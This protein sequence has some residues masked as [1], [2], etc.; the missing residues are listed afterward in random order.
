MRM[1]QVTWHWRIVEEILVRW[2]PY[3]LQHRYDMNQ[4]L[5]HDER[6]LPYLLLP[7]S[8]MRARR[9]YIPLTLSARST[10]WVI[11]WGCPSSGGCKRL[12]VTDSSGCESEFGTTAQTQLTCLCAI[13]KD[14]RRTSSVLWDFTLRICDVIKNPKA[15]WCIVTLIRAIVRHSGGNSREHIRWGKGRVK[16]HGCLGQRVE[17]KRDWI[18]LVKG[19][20]PISW[21]NVWLRCSMHRLRLPPWGSSW[22]AE[23]S[24]RNGSR[25]YLYHD[26]KTWVSLPNHVAFALHQCIASPT[27]SRRCTFPPSSNC[28]PT[29][30]S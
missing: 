12:S 2:Q 15:V 9:R 22:S 17:W 28:T 27:P 16:I 1:L 3:Q 14:L 25:V 30:V 20:P 23:G 18:L 8:P 6:V 29:C 10:G 5:L 24:I 19:T 4:W 7:D 13:W 11:A 21:T 26:G